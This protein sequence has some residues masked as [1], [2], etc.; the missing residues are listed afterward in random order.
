[1]SIIELALEGE[2]NGDRARYGTPGSNASN[3]IMK[4]PEGTLADHGSRR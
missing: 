1:V 3:G 4:V 2:G